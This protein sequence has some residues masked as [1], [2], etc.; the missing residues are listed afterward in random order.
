MTDVMSL[1]NDYVHAVSTDTD[2]EDAAGWPKHNSYKVSKALV[3]VLTRVAASDSEVMGDAGGQVAINCC[4]PGWVNTDM[5]GMMGP[6]PKT[7]EEG[8]RVPFELATRDLNGVTGE[9]WALP[10]VSE[11]SVHR[12]AVMD[13]MGS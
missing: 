2:N 6:A 11:K 13:W 8:A 4:C 3:N 10:S 1:R 7:P 12:L 9:Y 5:G